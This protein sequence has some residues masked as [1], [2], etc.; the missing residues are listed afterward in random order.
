MSSSE[1]FLDV[2]LGEGSSSCN[3]PVVDFK[4]I[5]FGGVGS[6]DFNVVSQRKLDTP[7]GFG[8]ESVQQP[9]L[10]LIEED[11]ESPVEGK[12]CVVVVS[13]RG[14]SNKITV[15]VKRGQEHGLPLVLTGDFNIIRDGSHAL[16]GLI[17]PV[18]AMREFNE[19]LDDID[20]VELSNHG[21]LFTWNSNRSEACLRKM[22][23]VFLST[24][25]T[26]KYKVFWEEHPSYL[27][28]FKNSWDEGCD[29]SMI[30]QLYCKV[31]S[32]ILKGSLSQE[33]IIEERNLRFEFA[34]LSRAKMSLIRDKARATWFEKGD[35]SM[36]F[37]FR[38]VLAYKNQHRI[39]MVMDDDGRSINEP[40]GIEE[41]EA[42][43]M[44]NAQP[45]QEE[46]KD[47]F[48]HMP[49]RKSPEPDG[50]RECQL[51]SMLLP[52]LLFLK[53]HIPA[54]SKI[55]YRSL[56]VTL[57]I[58]LSQKI[59]TN[60]SLFRG[61]MWRMGVLKASIKIDLQKAYDMVEWISLWTV[62]E[63]MQFPQRFIRIL[64]ACV[65]NAGFSMNING[66]L[67]GW[68]SSTRGDP[69]SSYLFILVL[70]VFNG[71]MRKA[72]RG[73]GFR[74]HPGTLFIDGNE[75]MD[76]TYEILRDS[77]VWEEVD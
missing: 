18:I 74:F 67:K 17:S 22:D 12:S 39:S 76:I 26:F 7:R 27:E 41:L 6:G 64:K 4:R 75:G 61:I 8:K 56:V 21:S 70:E 54:I 69:I 57:F 65:G 73:V 14:N 23:F 72:A 34:R 47:S 9:V 55:T 58:K 62:M 31:Q 20:V 45:S 42:C 51:R 19:C 50:L 16:G 53:W 71:L 24:P 63:A 10:P 13:R 37:F 5:V 1:G 3:T 38:S 52:C 40:K 11:E 43:V 68:C 2:A 30:D 32:V 28:V 35:L 44:L 60:R 33:K 29:G 36:S 49:T 15:Q 46:V 59:L 25:K 66:T 48:L 77:F